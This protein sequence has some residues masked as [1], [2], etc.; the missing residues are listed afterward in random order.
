MGTFLISLFLLSGCAPGGLSLSP[1]WRAS[2]LGLLLTDIG[3]SMYIHVY[4]YYLESFV[5]FDVGCGIYFY[6][7][8]EKWKRAPRLPV[9]IRMD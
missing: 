7:Q 2:S 8:G 4:R 1:R 3:P 9:T 5:Y 6:L